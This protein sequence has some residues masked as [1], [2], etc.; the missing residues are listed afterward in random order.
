MDPHDNYVLSVELHCKES[1]SRDGAQALM[2]A[3][4][5]VF[6]ARARLDRDESTVASR[7]FPSVG[8]IDLGRSCQ[9]A[10]GRHVVAPTKT[11]PRLG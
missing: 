2:Q 1:L 11:S 5:E 4:Q 7:F 10:I 8:Q 3:A 9:A 6:V